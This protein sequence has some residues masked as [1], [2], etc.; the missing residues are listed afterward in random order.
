MSNKLY[1]NKN[2]QVIF[3]VTL[4]AVLG[5]SMTYL[6]CDI[7]NDYWD[8]EEDIKNQ[9][10]DKLIPGNILSRNGTKKLA[11]M[12]LAFGLALGT[13]SGFYTLIFCA[14][15]AFLGFAYS[16]PL[17]RLKKFDFM[18]YAGSPIFSVYTRPSL[19]P[20]YLWSPLPP[21]ACTFQLSR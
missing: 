7:Y 18:A 3:S 1:L 17:I 12:V 14:F 8:F 16:N 5:L 20:R 10:K 2:L 11:Y 19:G 9:R 6:F 4:I 13:L 15:Y 21:A